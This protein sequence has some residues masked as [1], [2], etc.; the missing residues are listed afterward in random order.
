MGNARLLAIVFAGLPLTGKST[1]AGEVSKALNIRHIS[2]DDNIRLPIFGLP[3][4]DSYNA[5]V[6][7]EQGR[8]EMGQSYDLLLHA[9]RSHLTLERSVIVSATFSRSLARSNL[10]QI[11]KDYP[12]AKLRVIWCHFTHED[13][14]IVE[15]KN[16]LLKRT[17]GVNYFGGCNTLDHWL[18]D[19]RRYPYMEIPHL[20]LDTFPPHTVDECRENALCYITKSS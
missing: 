20:L 4:S 14:A 16:R 12:K 17:F 5:P 1:L 6:D 3:N 8:Q 9:I 15:I 2:I 13:L 7:R 19:R 10:L 18:D 11:I